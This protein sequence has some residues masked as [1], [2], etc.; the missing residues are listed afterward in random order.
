MTDLLPGFSGP[1]DSQ[2]CFRA[3]LEAFSRPGNI[4][5]LPEDFLAPPKNRSVAAA[6]VL[7]TLVDASTSV[8]LAGGA[9][10]DWLVFHTGA[11]LTEPAQ[12]DFV[13][14]QE[15][16]DFTT[17]RQGDDDEPEAAATVILDVANFATGLRCRLTGPGIE[18]ATILRLPIDQNFIAAW[19]AQRKLAPRGVDLLLCAGRKIIGLPRSVTIEEA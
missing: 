15:T 9:A 2:K 17:L 19:Q 5:T 13:V 14:T 6:G 8:S 12:A 11:R 10:C 16:P 1:A 18:T 4:I 3:V 7:L